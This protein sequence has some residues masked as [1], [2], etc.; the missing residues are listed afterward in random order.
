M[1]SKFLKGCIICITMLS[2]SLTQASGLSGKWSGMLKVTPQ[3]SLRIVF[4]ISES[5]NGKGTITMD[6]PDQNAYGIPAEVYHLT[7]DSVSLAVTA[8]NMKYSGRLDDGSIRGDFSQGGMRLP[9]TLTRATENQ[10]PQTPAPPFPYSRNE[11]KVTN[12]EA[13]VT[14]SGILT[15]PEGATPDTPA[16]IMVTGSGLQNRDEEIFG[17]KPFA[18]IADYLARNGIASFR[19]DDRGYGES[20]GDGSTATTADN[21]SDAAAAL[22]YIRKSGRFGKCGIL[23]HSEGGS[24][25]FMLGHGKTS[26]DFIV[27]IG[28][29]ATR[30]DS[31][32]VAQNIRNLKAAGTP[33]EIIEEYAG[34]L[35]RILQ[36]KIDNP[37]DQDVAEVIS[38][39]CKDWNGHPVFSALRQALERS[40]AKDTNPW[41]E[42]FIAY[43][44]AEDIRK[45]KIPM[46]LLYGEKDTQVDP[47]LNV[48]PVRNLAP[49]AA[50]KVYP[51][52]NHLMQHA[53]TG[54]VSEYAQIEE[55]VSEEVLADIT[56]FITDIK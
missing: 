52:L 35:R 17:H 53:S 18:V 37:A 56:R 19:Y 7:P 45:I 20:S 40:F 43:S 34:A 42:F 46:L 6:S 30:G 12:S 36:Y 48:P 29:P 49:K 23:G 55:T 33:D 16:V 51:G 50:V 9:L 15:V 14:L 10:R 32:I 1:N 41:T 3:V 28:A 21:A 8:I 44:P 25:A 39:V 5:E 26:P 24:V 54:S 2:A 38:T 47:S 11:L 27:T 31:I 13:G 4:N 22:D